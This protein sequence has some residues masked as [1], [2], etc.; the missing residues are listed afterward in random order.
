MKYELDDLEET[1]GNRGK[2]IVRA[3]TSALRFSGIGRRKICRAGCGPS[4]GE[5]ATD[6]EIEPPYR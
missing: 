5:S 3:K 6:F 2:N 1:V 4:A